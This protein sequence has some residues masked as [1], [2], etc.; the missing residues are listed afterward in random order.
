MRFLGISLCGLFL[1]MCLGAQALPPGVTR[2]PSVEGVT[3]YDLS[4]GLRV[5][6]FPDPTKTTTTVNITYL[7]GSRNEDYG[8]T[9]MAHLLEHLMFKGTPE[10]PNVPQ[11]LT[12]HGARPNGTT[13]YDRTNYFET[14]ESTDTNL[15]WALDLEAD[16]MVHSFI[17]KKD[18]D[19]EM[20]VVRN[21]LEMGE[22]NPTSILIERVFSTAYL[23]HNYGKSVI[24]AR[25]DLEHVPIERLQA[26][27]GRYYQPDNAVLTVAGHVDEAKTL[28]LI[29]KDFGSIPKPTRILQKTYTEEPTQDGERS[30]TLRR[31]GD[32]K[33]LIVGM[34][35]PALASPDGAVADLVGDIFG[36]APSGRLY[37]ALVETKKAGSVGAF[38]TDSREP[39][40]LMLY[41]QGTKA[42]D[43]GD[44]Q[45]TAVGVIDD[46][47]N[48]P[49]TEAEVN[50]AKTKSESR[51]DLLTRNSERLGLFLSEYIAAGDWR[52]AFLTRDRVKNATVA[53]V[54]RFARTYL[55]KSNRTVGL[56]IPI[57][58]PD[59][60]IIPPT[61]DVL[62]LVKDYKGG[63][64]M[65]AGESFDP[66]P[67]NIDKRTIRGELQP[68]IKLALISKKTRGEIV[69]ANMQLHF[70]NEANLHGK[71]PEA[72]LAAMMLNRG[73]SKHTRQQINDEFDRLKAQV[74]IN[75]SATGATVSI[76]TTKANFP[77]VL[78]LVA[79]ILREPSFPESEFEALKQQ[80]L[81]QLEAQRT[82]PM[83]IAF[84]NAERHTH[85]YPKGDVRYVETT[86]EEIA[87]IKG[88]TLA[89]VRD[90]Y[91]D[92]YGANKAEFAAV[93]D[94]EAESLQ[95]SLSTLFS[96][97]TS[98]AQ[99]QRVETNY[100]KVADVNQSF[101]TPDKANSVFIA[102]QPLKMT[103]ENPDY[104]A[105]LLSNY[106]LGGG[107]LNSRLAT[108]IRVK[109]GLSYGIGSQLNVPTKED[110]ASFLTYAISAP[111]NTAKVESDFYE[112]LKRAVQT[113]FT[114]SE[115]A[116]AK[117][118][119][120]QSRQVSR[121]QDNELTSRLTNQAF[122]GRTMDWDAQLES[123]VAKLTPDQVNAAIRKY[124]NPDEVSIFKAG[125]FAKAKTGRAADT[126]AK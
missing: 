126:S 95:K 91:A 55:K 86:D 76:Q 115:I 45:K 4:N 82:E 64:A 123:R 63:A 69:N 30:V 77:Q 122:W 34:H 9:G 22:N 84:Q 110:A 70:G 66:S 113:G 73:T 20:T 74:R 61:P 81:T 17:A 101:E 105:L 2:G 15:N 108:R 11:E 125:D 62:A 3:E 79:E 68:G 78:Q 43:L 37:K 36:N 7:V 71:A 52:L 112:E 85:P 47:E 96:G 107:F 39:G 75:G 24:G 28:A 44:I 40:M 26:F 50:R 5:L 93:G 31:V 53:D 89:S 104:P 16:R 32:A 100:Q 51:F 65:A 124:L 90:F 18:L 12:E 99:Y 46:V 111:Q 60:A 8:E 121:G 13:D 57:D 42:S 120:L 118:G 80:Q 27:Y 92:F 23:W 41:A 6:L 106:M 29:A 83:A 54:D 119:W 97:W 56:F 87:E 19:S 67:T 116:A 33:V 38:A 58:K 59:R 109:D 25:S 94:I 103:D 48:N 10:H 49:P 35:V 1:S 88:T 14:F 102:V 72:N 98:K 21:E 114:D 117:S